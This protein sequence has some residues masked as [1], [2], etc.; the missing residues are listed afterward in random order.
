M[1][2]GLP[3]VFAGHCPVYLTNSRGNSDTH[4]RLRVTVLESHLSLFHCACSVFS[5]FFCLRRMS[6]SFSF[7]FGFTSLL[8]PTRLPPSSSCVSAQSCNPIDCS[9]PGFSVRAFFQGRI[10]EWVAVSFS[11]FAISVTVTNLRF[12][13]LHTSI[14]LNMHF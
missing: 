5:S 7:S 13:E 12:L 3:R 1:F 9:P 4:K 6:I 14:V 11:I 8:L 2:S 10:L